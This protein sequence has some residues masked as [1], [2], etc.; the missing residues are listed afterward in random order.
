MATRASTTFTVDV[1]GLT[2][3]V[4]RKNVKNVNFRIAADG[5]AHMSVPRHVSNARAREIAL[6]HEQWFKAHVAKA[7]ERRVVGPLAWTTG[8]ELL[9]W[10]E[11]RR[12]RVLESNGA[13]GCTLGEG[14]LE[15]RVPFGATARGKEAFVDRWL[16]EELREHVKGMLATCEDAL[17]VRAT[18]IT[19]RRMKTRWGSC[20]CQ[21]GRIRLNVALAECPPACAKTVLVHELCHLREPNHGRR[22]H[23]LMDLHCP[24][25]RVWQRWLDEHPPRS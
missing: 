22:F 17:G 5:T 14:E 18:S 24:D 10:G 11:P 16:A 2:V 15:I 7:M 6:C 9:V 1:D 25:W 3:R 13:V 8:E 20:T 19:L 4:T 12:L 23:A 21:T